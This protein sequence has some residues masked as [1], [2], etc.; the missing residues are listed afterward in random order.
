[1]G[2]VFQYTSRAR[3]IATLQLWIQSLVL[4][5]VIYTRVGFDYH[6]VIR[7]LKVA[8]KRHLVDNRL[9]SYFIYNIIR[10]VYTINSVHNK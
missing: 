2:E 10:L 9:I 4:E 6:V 1:M 7:G 8:R 3:K 5:M